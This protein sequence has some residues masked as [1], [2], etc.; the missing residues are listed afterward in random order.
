MSE[1]V[2]KFT[3][4]SYTVIYPV[5]EH[6]DGLRLDQFLMNYL[7]SFS[8]EM[9]KKKIRRG[10]VKI[11]ERD[12]PNKGSV[13]VKH[14]EKIRVSTQKSHLEDEYWQ[15]KKIEFEDPEIIFE[16]NDLLI[17][18]KPPYMATHPTGRHLFFTAVTYFEEH[19][20][21]QIFTTH[22]LDRE[23]SGC[24]ILAKNTQ[25]ASK[26]VRSFENSKVKKAYFFLAH[27]NILKLI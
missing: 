26:I 2:K 1:R 13:R 8:R 21:N 9:I 27:K 15:G 23:T 20:K 19:L 4:E 5:F 25:S 22:R 3:Q 18:S 11:L 24:L 6:E 7:S 14:R 12:H 10:D 16:D 17:I